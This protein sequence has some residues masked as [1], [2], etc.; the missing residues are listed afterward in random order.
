M[1]YI[2]F[3]D[4]MVKGVAFTTEQV[5][6]LIPSFNITNLY[7]WV[8]KGYLIKL[9]NGCYAFAESLKEQD[10][11]FFLSQFI[12]RPSYVS[13]ESALSLY[14]VIPETVTD[15]TSVTTLGTKTFQ[16]KA[17]HFSY[18][19]I[20]SKLFWGYEKRLMSDGILAYYIASLEKAILD[21]LYLN[22]FYN[23]TDELLNLRF[24]D[25][26]MTEVLDKEK[27]LDYTN[28]FNVSSLTSRV[29]QLLTLYN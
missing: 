24:D 18:R 19:T 11:S 17:G 8:E 21:L 20:S 6:V 1:N 13:L 26:I 15:I 23:S 5:K 27:L 10:Y 25:Y 3:R 29:Q 4:L 7:R 22:T 16:S 28:R 12:Y 2:A 9:R 14:G